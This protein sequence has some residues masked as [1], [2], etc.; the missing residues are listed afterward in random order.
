MEAQ[1]TAVKQYFAASQPVFEKVYTDLAMRQPKEP[2]TFLAEAFSNLS[3]V[4]KT[5]WLVAL[6]V[7][8]AAAAAIASKPKGEEK[9]TGAA[10]PPTAALRVESSEVQGIWLIPV[11]PGEDAR[12][13]TVS[14][15][16]EV[17]ATAAT[18]AH[19]C[20]RFEIF[21]EKPSANSLAN[22][23]QVMHTWSSASHYDRF[24]AHAAKVTFSGL[25]SGQPSHQVFTRS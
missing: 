9:K 17:R 11:K 7:A 18:A 4:D 14:V 10:A 2:W 19:G 25:V 24:I 1:K 23:I 22:N 12:R 5:E 3:T 15:L 8:E 21:V 13:G 20:L 6:G 16:S